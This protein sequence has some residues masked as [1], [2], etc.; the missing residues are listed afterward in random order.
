MVLTGSVSAQNITGFK[1]GYLTFT[2]ENTGIYYRVEFKPNLM[3]PVDWDGTYK[4]LRNIQYS[5]SEVTVPVG[6]FYRVFGQMY[7]FVAGTA[8]GA[9]ILVGKT[10]YVDDEEVSGT[11]V[12]VGSTNIMP[13]TAAQAIEEGYHDGTGAVAGDVDLL[14]AKIKNHVTI[15]GVTG[16]LFNA[17]VPKTGQTTS[18][19]A[20][21]DGALQKGVAWPSPRFTDNSNGTVTDN[22]T[23]LIWLKN[24]NFKAG[25]R[26]WAQALSDCATLNSGEGGLTDGAVEGDWRLPNLRELQSLIDHGRSNP[27]IPSGHPFT[28]V[29]SASYW[30]SS[31]SE[32]NTT[33]ARNVGLDDSLM[34][35]GNKNDKHFVWPV[36]SGQ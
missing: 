6:V 22:L 34:S 23:G 2:N 18:Y 20:R 14:A 1:N 28:G 33:R 10:A 9:D 11:M 8:S 35:S 13:G 36:R 17:A 24:A 27:A 32:D 30:S 7:P 12:N 19:A 26:T 5:A 31:T 4:N 29:Q 3:D 21:D 15:F 16:T 25:S